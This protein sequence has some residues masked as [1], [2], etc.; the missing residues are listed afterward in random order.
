MPNHV[1]NRIKII[2]TPEQIQEVVEK[3]GTVHPRCKNLA[4]GGDTICHPIKGEQFDVGWLNEETNEFSTRVDG[5]IKVVGLGIPEGWEI[6][7]NEEFTQFPDFNKI[8]PMPKSL[9]VESSSL[10]DYGV[11]KLT[12]KMDNMFM[13]AAEYEKR[14]NE[15]SQE[16]QDKALELGKTY[17]DNQKKYGHTTWYTWC[18]E[19]WGTKW[20]TYSCEKESDDVYTFETAWSGV[21]QMIE[22]MSMLYPE[23]SFEYEYS[24]EDFGYNCGRGIFRNGV[25]EFDQ[26]EGGSNEAYELALKLRPDYAQYYKLVDGK[27]EYVE[28]EDE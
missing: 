2:G 28:D 3:F 19:H 12:G 1:K 10:G 17:L 6:D 20:N 5:E 27:Y 9:S 18:C 26:L 22:Q 7:Y 13:S 23:V 24:D 25:L 16:Q 11:F 14:F 8:N 15:M 21:P 4:Y